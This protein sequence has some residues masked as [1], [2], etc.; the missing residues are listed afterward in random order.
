[1]LGAG[2]HVLHLPAPHL[3][4]AGVTVAALEHQHPLRPEVRDL[5]DLIAEEL[6]AEYIRLMK[7]VAVA[8]SREEV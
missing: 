4:T 6:A 3:D 8:E 1:M 7:A 5:L 2:G